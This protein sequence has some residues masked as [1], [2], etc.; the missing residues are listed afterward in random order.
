MKRMLL[1]GLIVCLC[2]AAWSSAALGETAKDAASMT[3]E[4]LFQAA[5]DAYSAND[6]EK[7]VECYQL[8]ADQ[9]YVDAMYNLGVMYQGGYGVAQDFAKAMEYY[10]KSVDNGQDMS[11]YGIGYLYANGQ[12][13]EQD[14]E[15]ALECYQKALD[16]GNEY[17]NTGYGDLYANGNGVEQDYEK[18]AEYYRKAMEAGDPMAAE[19]LNRLIEEG[20][21]QE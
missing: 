6:Y 20:H 7:A 12:G 18:A 4:E 3:A 1:F 19:R 21:I 9:G 2:L 15:K 11:Y 10:Q 8:A 14:Y 17:A 13:V 16:A 5:K